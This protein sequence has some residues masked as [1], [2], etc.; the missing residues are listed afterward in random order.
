MSTLELAAIE[1]VFHRQLNTNEAVRFIMKQVGVDS[2][3]AERSIT[4]AATHYKNS[5][6]NPH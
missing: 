2:T 1:A 3:T 5:A 4:E 6:R